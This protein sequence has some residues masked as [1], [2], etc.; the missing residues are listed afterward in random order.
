[1]RVGI[2]AD[3]A[4]VLYPLEV[5]FKPAGRRTQLGKI[6]IQLCDPAAKIRIS[7][8]QKDIFANLSGFQCG[9]QAT[10]ATANDQYATCSRRGLFV[11][12]AVPP[13]IEKISDIATNWFLWL[14]QSALSDFS[15]SHT[16]CLPDRFNQINHLCVKAFIYH[17]QA[18]CQPQVVKP[19]RIQKSPGTKE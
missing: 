6:L 8:H 15:Y 18:A 17:F 13:F 11:C 12:H 4:V 19:L 16:D 1:L 3:P 2:H 14:N 5:D 7:F 10:D 9:R